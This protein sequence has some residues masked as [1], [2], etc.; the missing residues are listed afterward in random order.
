MFLLILNMKYLCCENIVM[1]YF[2]SINSI[3]LLL[4]VS[5]ELLPLS[6]YVTCYKTNKNILIAIAVNYIMER[7]N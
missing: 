5:S 3:L 6:H 1:N 7:K 4:I 2:N